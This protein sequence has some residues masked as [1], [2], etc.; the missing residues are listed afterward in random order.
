MTRWLMFDKSAFQG[1]GEAAHEAVR[2]AYEVVT[3]PS[4]HFEIANDLAAD[5]EFGRR[6]PET[7]AAI[8]ARKFGD[9]VETHLH[10][11]RLCEAS[12]L[13]TSVR[14]DG[15]PVIHNAVDAIGP[16][17]KL[18]PLLTVAPDGTAVS[19]QKH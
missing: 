1:L 9:R 16:K 10:W 18:V 14:L 17:G 7:H 15:T 11:E 2:G 3:A 4:L 13:G 6:S 12:L 5:R 8:L 19:P